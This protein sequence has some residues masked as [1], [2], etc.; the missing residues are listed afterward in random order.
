MHAGTP[1]ETANGAGTRTGSQGP[2]IRGPGPA[3]EDT[4]RGLRGTAWP[5]IPGT[6]R[7]CGSEPGLALETQTQ[8]QS[9]GL[10]GTG[11]GP[12]SAASQSVTGRGKGMGEGSGT[13]TGTGR[14]TGTE[15]SGTGGSTGIARSSTGSATGGTGTGRRGATG[16]LRGA[17]AERGRPGRQTQQRLSGRMRQRQ[18]QQ[19]DL[20]WGQTPAAVAEMPAGGETGWFGRTGRPRLSPEATAE[21]GLSWTDLPC[22]MRGLGERCRAK[23]CQ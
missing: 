5:T 15:M 16:G 13:G 21:P 17:G 8:G 18:Q 6:R 14:R 2:Q 7:P 4:A 20:A 19:V 1:R 23:V 10:T 9:T 3:A 22:Q 11:P 12:Q